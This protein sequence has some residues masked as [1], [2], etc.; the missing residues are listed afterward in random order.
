MTV[1]TS[2]SCAIRLRKDERYVI[3]G[4][5]AAGARDLVRPSSFSFP[6]DGNA[7]LLSA[8]RNAEAG[9]RSRL[10]GKVQMKE[11]DYREGEPGVRVVATAGSNLL[12]SITNTSGE[13]EFLNVAPGQYR[14]S[15]SS[16]GYF[17][18]E[19][20]WPREDPRAGS[21]G[22]RYQSLHVWPDGRVEGAVRNAQGK[23]LA[24]V[25]VQVFAVGKDGEISYSPLRE[26]KTG[27]DG[28]YL[29]R[30]LPAGEFIVGVNGEKSSDRFPWPPAFYPGTDDRDQAAR[31]H[32]GRGEKQTGVDLQ[33]PPPRTPAVVHVEVVFEAGNPS[34]MAAV[35]LENLSGVERASS[36]GDRASKKVWD[37]P[38]YIGE[39]YY[40][41]GR[42]HFPGPHRLH[43]WSGVAGPIQVASPEVRV[44]VVLKREKGN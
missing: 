32:L 40:V 15:V 27:G 41:K 10:V 34:S 13:F 28:T 16:E 24:G 29:L 4:S 30:G 26:Q 11:S 8:L 31:L 5:A 22:C 21:S 7:T 6:I 12:E 43:T 38:A 35:T 36:I 19:W 39:T 2:D 37:L 20:R 18:D 25:P 44:Q 33:L 17:E 1:D 42:S 3:F 23:L 9:G 14:L